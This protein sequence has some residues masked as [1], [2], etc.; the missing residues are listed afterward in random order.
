[1][2]LLD[3]SPGCSSL[4][5]GLG[6]GASLLNLGQRYHRKNTSRRSYMF[7]RLCEDELGGSKWSMTST[8]PDNVP[9]WR[10]RVR[11]IPSFLCLGDQRS[12]AY[13]YTSRA[14][15]PVSYHASTRSAILRYHRCYSC[16][17]G[18]TQEGL[19]CR[20]SRWEEGKVRMI[21]RHIPCM[22]RRMKLMQH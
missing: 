18:S 8:E 3:V 20:R 22:K 19:R 16:L 21:S 5:V 14:L 7:G 4:P 17:S 12:G 9:R 6:T 10:T 13:D 2:F 15:C 11:S 1:M